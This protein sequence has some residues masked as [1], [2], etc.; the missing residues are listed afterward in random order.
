[1]GGEPMATSDPETFSEV[2]LAGAV[3]GL[4]T[5]GADCSLNGHTD[6]KITWAKLCALRHGATTAIQKCPCA[7]N[8]RKTKK[9]RQ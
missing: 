7:V 4:S 1:M 3:I 9:A 8:K 6:P 2:R 5:R